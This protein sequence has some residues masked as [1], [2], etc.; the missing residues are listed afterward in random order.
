MFSTVCL[1]SDKLLTKHNFNFYFHNFKEPKRYL[2][3]SKNPCWIDKPGDV[4][5]LR[6]IPYF[7]VAGVAKCGTSDLFRRIRLHPEVMKGTMKEY[8][9]WDRTRFGFT[10]E[11]GMTC[12]YHF[13][14][15]A[16]YIQCSKQLI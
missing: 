14:R 3:N 5:T 11:E 15:K 6:C 16:L 1:I 12:A 8:H 4:R 13:N 9:W 2:P 10:D 7:Y